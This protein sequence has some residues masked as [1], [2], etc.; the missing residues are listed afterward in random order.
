MKLFVPMY[1]LTPVAVPMNAV[2]ETMTGAKSPPPRRLMIAGSDDPGTRPSPPRRGISG[3]KTTRNA[4]EADDR[5]KRMKV[6]SMDDCAQVFRRANE[7]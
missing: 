7:L 2:A 1:M 3:V 5:Q 6:H 4:D